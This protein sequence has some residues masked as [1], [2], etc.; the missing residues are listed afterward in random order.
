MIKRAVVDH[1]L[2]AKQLHSSGSEASLVVNCAGLG[3]M[4]LGGVRDTQMF[5]IRGQTVLVRNVPDTMTSVHASDEK[6]DEPAYVLPRAAG[7]SS[8]MLAVCFDEPLR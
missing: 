4:K 8:E 5:P 3:A 1:I 2:D 6:P 7:W